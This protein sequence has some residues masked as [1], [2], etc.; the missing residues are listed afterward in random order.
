[1]FW[2]GAG[3]GS[4]PAQA[5]LSSPAV[6]DM[7]HITVQPESQVVAKG[8]RVSLT[9]WATGPPGLV[10][11]WFCGK[12]EVRSRCAMSSRAPRACPWREH[13]DGWVGAPNSLAPSCLVGA[14]S[15]GPGAGD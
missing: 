9:C 8:T 2:D 6:Q 13:P 7:I 10:Y 3:Q 11:Q 1:M 5:S 12:R 15:H 4:Q 14:R